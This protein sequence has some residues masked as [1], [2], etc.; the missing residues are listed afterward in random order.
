MRNRCALPTR[1]ARLNPLAA[2]GGHFVEWLRGAGCQMKIKFRLVAARAPSDL[3]L[4]ALGDGLESGS[5]VVFETLER[6]Q[7]SLKR[8]EHLHPLWRS[9]PIFRAFRLRGALAGCAAL[10]VWGMQIRG[11]L[12][13]A[14]GRGGA[15]SLVPGPVA[16]AARAWPP[17]AEV[18]CA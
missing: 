12:P 8:K 5:T 6:G 7:R 13:A 9:Y 10:A 14:S 11:Q 3:K 15:R 16:L 18:G 2:V 4:T 17:K 1:N